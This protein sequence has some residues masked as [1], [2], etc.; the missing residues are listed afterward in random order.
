MESGRRRLAVIGVVVSSS[1]LAVCGLSCREAGP[2]A[3]SAAPAPPRRV[4]EFLGEEAVRVL[5]APTKVQRFRLVS[6]TEG[7]GAAADAAPPAGAPET[8]PA[9]LHGHP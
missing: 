6:R 8:A 9:K 7:A 3:P 2:A 5:S 1:F 4:R